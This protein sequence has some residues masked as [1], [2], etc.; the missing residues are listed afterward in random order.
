[1]SSFNKFNELSINIT[2]N[3]NKK[4]KKDFGIYFTPLSIIKKNLELLDNYFV[5]IKKILEPSCG[6]CEYILYLE[7]KYKN[8]NITGIEYNNYIYNNIKNI[9]FKKSKI[10]NNDYLLYET[11]DKYDLII[12][13]PPYFI[14]PKKNIH[15]DYYDFI[16][17]RPNIYIY[18]L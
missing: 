18:Y 7:N 9:K 12:G 8:I 10:I 2:K 4:E 1:M 14:I 3:I 15:K 13:N 6:S 5:N 16:D 11:N 17:G